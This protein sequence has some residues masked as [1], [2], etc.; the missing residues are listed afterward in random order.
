SYTSLDATVGDF[1]RDGHLDIAVT[2][3]KSDTTRELPAFIYWG[4]GSRHFSEKRRTAL[5]AASSSA[6]AAFDLDRDGWLDLIVS[7]HQVNFDHAAGTEIY[8]GGSQGFSIARRSHLPTVG[9]HLNA[10]TDAGNIYD[11]T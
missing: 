7:N 1:N 8:W 4:D 3:Y 9:V 5:P 10:M 2:N 6:I 11:R